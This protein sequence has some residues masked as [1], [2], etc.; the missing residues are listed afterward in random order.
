MIHGSARPTVL[1]ARADIARRLVLDDWPHAVL[2][3]GRRFK[4]AGARYL[5][6]VLGERACG[7]GA[8]P[9]G[10]FVRDA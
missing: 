5:P 9:V 8:T 2:F 1:A 7:R 4:Q 3:S 10:E 6:A